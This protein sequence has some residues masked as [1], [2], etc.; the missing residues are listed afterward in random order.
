MQKVIVVSEEN[1]GF[2]CVAKDFQSAVDFLIS[3]DWIT[4]GTQVYNEAKSKWVCLDELYGED[5]EE[6]VRRLL[7]KSFEELFDG[8]FYFQDEEIYGA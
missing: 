7:R 4:E 8:C 1:H 3:D 6:E 5:W 2:L